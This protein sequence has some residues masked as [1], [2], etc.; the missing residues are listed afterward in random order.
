MVFDPPVLDKV[1][2][3]GMPVNLKKSESL[4]VFA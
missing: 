3:A 2:A 4:P 1:G